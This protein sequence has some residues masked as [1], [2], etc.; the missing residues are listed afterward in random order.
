KI[1]T[2]KFHTEGLADF[3]QNEYY[4][5]KE[6]DFPYSSESLKKNIDLIRALESKVFYDN[7]SQDSSRKKCF[8][9]A[10]QDVFGSFN[11]KDQVRILYDIGAIFMQY[12][13]EKF[14]KKSRNGVRRIN[15]NKSYK[16]FQELAVASEIYDLLE[17]KVEMDL[18][19]SWDE[20]CS[21]FADYLRTGI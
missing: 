13:S 11:A 15:Y 3:V 18:G 21:G 6:G 17:I 10:P 4:Y 5:K 19:E 14:D 7:K 9:D 12:V 2:I 16:I 8:L 1:W 20:F